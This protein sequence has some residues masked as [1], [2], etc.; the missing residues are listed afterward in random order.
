[1]EKKTKKSLYN[2]TVDVFVA[3]I[4]DGE[5]GVVF[6]PLRN[7][8]I[9]AC[10]NKKVKRQK[11]FVWKLL[12]YAIENSLGLK[13][14]ELTFDKTSSG[15]WVTNACEISLTHSDEVVAVALSIN[16]VGIDIEG[17]R[18]IRSSLAKKTLCER[19]YQQF[20]ALDKENQSDYFIKKWTQKESLF[21][22][23]YLDNFVPKNILADESK[24]YSQKTI[25]DG[26]EY[27]LSV[28]TDTPD[29]VRVYPI[30]NLC[31][32]VKS[33]PANKKRARTVAVVLSALTGVSAMFVASN[34]IAY[35][36]FFARFPRPDYDITP[37]LISYERIAHALPRETLTFRSGDNDLCAYYYPAKSSKGLVMVAHGFRAGADDYL[38]IIKKFVDSGFSVF[39]HDNTGTYGSD[40]DTMIGMCQPLVDLDNAIKFVKSS[41]KF[42]DQPLFLWGHSLGGYAVNSVLALHDGINACATVASVN[43]GYN[44]MSQ[45]ATQYAGAIAQMGKPVFNAYQRVLFGDYVNYDALKGINSTSIP[46]VIAHGKTDS[47]I[48]YGEQSAISKRALI[49]NPNV[50]YY[51]T[52]GEQGGHNEI[53]HSLSALNYRKEIQ[54]RL[55]Q[56][57]EQ[58]GGEL[59]REQMIEFN[60]TV[61]HVLYS[62][63]NDELMDLIIKTF[64]STLK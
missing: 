9:C 10:K 11:Y 49:T 61:D 44:I 35:D 15:K 63:V 29:K 38:P 62:F 3:P 58:N 20:C 26:K 34:I 30:V 46:V 17:V 7:E 16:P 28:A 32:P 4:P 27:Y 21:K 5:I 57:K 50:I 43:S 33:A 56:L 8:E 22:Q 19:E 48:T 55:T 18:P 51:E 1:M 31:E 60:E 53:M 52:D 45:K 36:S 6:P 37:G 12:E 42:S 2:T 25:I 24:V 39:A 13:M 59:T 41:P 64:N 14:D 40:G 23:S 54:A 47:I